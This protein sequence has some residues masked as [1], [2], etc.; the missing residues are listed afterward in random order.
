MPPV[1]TNESI[2]SYVPLIKSGSAVLEVIV[3]V[4]PCNVPVPA[5]ER[6]WPAEWPEKSTSSKGVGAVPP[7]TLPS[8]LEVPSKS[9]RSSPV[10]P[11]KLPVTMTLPCRFIMSSP[12]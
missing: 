10:P 3:P 5:I 7:S 1:P 12:P 8:T 11:S 6:T 9:N 4:L 2:L